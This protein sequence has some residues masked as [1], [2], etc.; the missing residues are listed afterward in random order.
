[1]IY[2]IF[3]AL[4]TEIFLA[5]TGATVKFLSLPISTSV[6]IVAQYSTALVILLPRILMKPRSGLKTQCFRLHLVRSLSGM[7]PLLQTSHSYIIIGENEVNYE[8][9]TLYR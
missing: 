5:I 8:W 4:A 7:D 1:M 2:G 3:Y 9:K 6:I